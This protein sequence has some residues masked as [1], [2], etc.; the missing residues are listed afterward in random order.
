MSRTAP[1]ALIVTLTLTCPALAG[2]LGNLPD[3]D[4]IMGGEAVAELRPAGEQQNLVT[5]RLVEVKGMPFTKAVEIETLD[6]A[7]Y[8]TDVIVAAPTKKAFRAGDLLFLSFYMQCPKNEN[9]IGRG[10]VMTSLQQGRNDRTLMAEFTAGEDWKQC[11]VRGKARVDCGPGEASLRLVVGYRPQTIR[12]AE[13]EILNLGNSVELDDLPAMPFEYDGIEPDAQWREGARERI[14]KHR[15]SDITVRVLDA[16][17]APVEGAQVTVQLKRHAYGFGA[18]YISRLHIDDK[19]QTDLATYQEHF[20]ALFNKAVLPDAL[21][22]K[23]YDEKGTTWAPLAYEWLSSNDIPVRGHNMIWPGWNFLP[24]WLRQYENDPQ[25]LREL[26]MERID[27]VMKDW[28]G[29]LAEWDVTN[30]VWRQH[31]LMDICGE[32]LILEWYKHMRELDPGTKLYYNDANTLVN[33]QPG[34]QDHYYETIKRMLE[35]GAPVDG[36][37]FESHVHSFV[38]PEV[39]YRRIERFAELGPEI[40]VTEFDVGPSGASEE[41]LAQYT[42][43]FMTV[44][45]SHPKTVGIVTWLGGNP[46]RR[47]ESSQKSHRGQA[48]FFDENWNI[49]PVGKAWRDLVTQE[50]HTNDTG[51]TGSNGEYKTRGFHGEYEIKV[52]KNGKTRAVNTTVGKDHQVEAV[53]E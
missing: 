37:G 18:T 38:P 51:T 20:K 39:V 50:W 47:I 7:K 2:D 26:T 15:K 52:T 43:D 19:F 34:H 13:L 33:N 21:K 5:T 9:D 49:T 23:Q 48:A 3:G 11:Y 25:K 36:M 46:L 35:Q 10:I 28:S 12:I 41:L 31:V 22:W 29:K 27:T 24:E 4:P 44:V 14:E 53:L 8:Y 1:V 6:T 42:R 30:E 32:D 16:K 17:G 40:Q 45:F